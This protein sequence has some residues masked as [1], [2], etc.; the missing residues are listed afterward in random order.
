M[1]Q[2]WLDLGIWNLWNLEG[3]NTLPT[4]SPRNT[5]TSHCLNFWTMVRQCKW[6]GQGT[7]EGAFLSFEIVSLSI[8]SLRSSLLYCILAEFVGPF[9]LP[10]GLLGSLFKPQMSLLVPD[11]KAILALPF[12]P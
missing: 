4:P 5:H 10:S 6:D 7:Q 1:S 2:M 11:L 8:V 12:G 9:V 3:G